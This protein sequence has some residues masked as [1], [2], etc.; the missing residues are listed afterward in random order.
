MEPRILYASLSALWAWISAFLTKISAEKNYNS[1]LYTWYTF[2]S[3]AFFSFLF[4][5]YSLEHLD[6]FIFL[7]IIWIIMGIAYTMTIISKIESLKNISTTIYFP[8]Y[9]V[10]ST[11]LAFIIWISFFSDTIKTNEIMGVILWLLVPLVL[12]NKKEHL[13][14]KNLKKGLFMCI[15]SIIFAVITVSMSKIVNFYELN[16]FFYI[17]VWTFTWW[18]L[19]LLQYNKKH[20]INTN[21]ISKIKRIS[22]INWF[23]IVIWSIFFVKALSWNFWVVYTINSFSILIPMILSVIFYKDNLD[24][25]K[26]IAIILTILSM[27]FFKVF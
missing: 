18:I 27:L 19:S 8:L 2:L 3:A 12:I 1:F 23:I 9:K 25:R 5:I 22:I 6:K 7:L 20:K 14:H 11:I 21:S 26:I 16:L 10:I 4:Y 13:K 17:F 15:I 24:L